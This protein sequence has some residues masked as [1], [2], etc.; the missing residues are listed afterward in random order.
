MNKLLESLFNEYNI[1]ARLFPAFLCSF[2]FLLI[3]HFV[4]DKYFSIPLD[5]AVIGDI[6][7]VI[8]LI[9]LLSQINRFVSK[10]FFEDKSRFPTT[11]MLMP[12]DT[13][14]SVGY[15]QKIKDKV[16]KDF[17][18]SIPTLREEY[19]SSENAKTRIK[20][21][22]SLIIDKVRSGNLLLQHNI[23]YGFMRNLIGGSVVAFIISFINSIVFGY[24]FENKIAYIT[25]IILCFVYLIPIIFSKIILDHYSKEYARIL[26]REYLGLK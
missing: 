16:K 5:T 18:I 10:L 24:I 6:P 20:E 17:Q 8:V 1:K 13:Q 23:E 9:Y 2:P 19:S 11:K 26:F 7:F 14:L 4:V 15:K 3:K 25:S 21:I 12:S 22:V